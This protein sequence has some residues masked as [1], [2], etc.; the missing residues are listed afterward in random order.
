MDRGAVLEWNAKLLL[1]NGNGKGGATVEGSSMIY[2]ILVWF[3][4][5]LEDVS[6]LC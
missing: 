4:Q 1:N 2:S 6:V 5:Y 3:A